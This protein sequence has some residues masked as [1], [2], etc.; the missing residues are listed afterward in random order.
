MHMTYALDIYCMQAEV[1]EKSSLQEKKHSTRLQK[2][3]VPGKLGSSCLQ[4]AIFFNKQ[5]SF[6]NIYFSH[7]TVLHT[8]A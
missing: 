2:N 7:K 1:C 4:I 3:I 5:V 8:K 6:K